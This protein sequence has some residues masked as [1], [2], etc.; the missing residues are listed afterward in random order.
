MMTD[1]S[2][3]EINLHGEPIGTLT[4]LPGDRTIFAFNDAY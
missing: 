2:I 4:R 1:V 3:L